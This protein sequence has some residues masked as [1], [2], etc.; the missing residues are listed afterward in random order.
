MSEPMTPERLAEIREEMVTPFPTATHYAEAAFGWTTELLNEV[1]RLRAQR[2]KDIHFG[3]GLRSN[4]TRFDTWLDFMGTR[5]TRE[6]IPDPKE[7]E[8]RIDDYLRG[9]E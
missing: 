8:E 2:R 4:M 7:V 9:G 5:Q 1:D 6:I 3:I